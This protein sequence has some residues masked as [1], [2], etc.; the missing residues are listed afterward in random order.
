MN[1]TERRRVALASV[2]TL[3]ALPALWAFNLGSADDDGA[4]TVGAAGEARVGADAAPSTAPYDP[5]PPLF[6]GGDGQPAT[7]GIVDVAVP[8]VPGANDILIKA[9]FHRYANFATRFCT[10]LLA[11]DGAL[12][13]VVN[14][15]NGQSTSCTN[16]LGMAVPA[17]ADIVLDTDVYTEIADLTDAPVPVR[18]T[19]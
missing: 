10:T 16:T 15:N 11:P 6:V 3:V 13:T 7:P 19:W 17:G 2:F 18:A 8:P 5:G 1:R 9:S 14:L 12:L 4:A